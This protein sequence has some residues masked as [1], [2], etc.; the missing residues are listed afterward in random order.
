MFATLNAK[1]FLRQKCLRFLTLYLHS[2]ETENVC[3]QKSLRFYFTHE[4]RRF[5][6]SQ[7]FMDLQYLAVHN[8]FILSA[9]AAI[10]L[11]INFLLKMLCGLI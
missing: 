9:R 3:V 5:N 2:N 7:T 10:D 1:L 11:N 8:L 4:I 6:G